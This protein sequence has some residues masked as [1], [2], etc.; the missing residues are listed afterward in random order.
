MV[1]KLKIIL[2]MIKFEHTVFALPFAYFGAILGSFIVNETWP[3]LMQWVWITVAM[4]GARS[5][6]MSLNRVIDEKIDKY[7]PRTADRAIPAGLISKI[8]VMFFII[9]SFAML[10]YAAFQLNQLAVYLLPLAVFF[11]VIYSYTKRFT[12]ACHLILGITIA[13]APLGGWVAV[14]GSVSFE[15]F[16][17][18]TAVALWTAGFDVIYATQDA[19]YDRERGLYSIPSRFGIRK[20]LILAKLFHVISF[21]AF[22]LLFLI[23]PLSWLYLIGVI[24]AGLIMIYEHSLVSA[25]DLSKVGVAFFTMNG[26]LSLVMF[27]FTVGDVWL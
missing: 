9:I 23:T 3:T 16:V 17:L 24:I 4:V 12:W 8:E 26:I 22:F 18:F 5:A 10:I 19:D 27:I 15:A 2:E 25:D 6:A 7:N 14:T 21:A 1:R 13:L 20:A 11:L